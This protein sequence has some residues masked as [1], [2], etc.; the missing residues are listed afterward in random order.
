M[1]IR[2]SLRAVAFVVY[3]LALLG[4]AF[5]ISYAVFEWQD[6]DEA[7]VTAAEETAAAEPAEVLAEATPSPY[8]RRLS[9]AEAAALLEHKWNQGVFALA[10][11]Q[12]GSEIRPFHSYLED[13]ETADFNEFSKAWVVQCS[14][15][16]YNPD[17]GEEISRFQET[18]LLFDETSSI[19]YVTGN[20][21]YWAS[22]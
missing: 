2:I 18:Y 9:G 6:S 3:T 1:T 7:P 19:T 14:S 16:T 22:D 8:Q 5:G 11:E 15:I 20:R 4:G 21:P 13:C 12:A 10:A 17:T